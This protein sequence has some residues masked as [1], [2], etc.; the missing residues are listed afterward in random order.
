MPQIAAVID[1]AEFAAAK[2]D[3]RVLRFLAEADA[4]L[5]MLEQQGRNR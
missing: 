3:L 4:Y 1:S 5:V 2:R